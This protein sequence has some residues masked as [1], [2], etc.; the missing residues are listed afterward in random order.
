MTL[1]HVFTTR[2]RRRNKILGTR[3]IAAMR[4]VLK[5]LLFLLGYFSGVEIVVR[6]WTVGVCI[7]IFLIA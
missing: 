7:W 5:K 3:V 2:Q 6:K 1:T 4:F